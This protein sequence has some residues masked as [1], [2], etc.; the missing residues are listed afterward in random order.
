[1]PEGRV[2]GECGV[3]E[4]ERHDRDA[5]ARGL[6]QYP[7]GVGVAYAES[8]FVDGVVGSGGDDNRVR[9]WQRAAP[10]GARLGVFASHLMAGLHVEGVEVEKVQRS[11][12]RDDVGIP[13]PVMGLV[14]QATDRGCG[15]GPAYDHVQHAGCRL[16]GQIATP[17]R[18]ASSSTCRLR[19]SGAPARVS[20]IS[21]WTAGRPDNSCGASRSAAQSAW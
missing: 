8:P 6:G 18:C 5:Q 3:D 10:A 11:G 14:D 12:S 2:G 15:A 13:S 20:L 1:M 7:E 19:P 4:R 16:V 9:V 21:R 17:V